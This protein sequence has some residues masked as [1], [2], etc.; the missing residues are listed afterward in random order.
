M[1]I[2]LIGAHPDDV[3]IGAGGF[4]AKM[5]TPENELMVVACS[6]CEEQEGNHGITEEFRNSMK[7]LGIENFRMLDFPNTRMPEK[8]SDIRI[9]MEKLKQSF[10]PDLVVTH[11]INNTHQDHKTIAEVC[12]RVFREKSIFMFEELRSTPKFVHNLIV[13]LEKEHLEK[14][15]MALECYKTQ[16]RRYYF[17]MDYVRSLAGV[18]GKVV[19]REFAEAFE[20]YQHVW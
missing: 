16:F 18:R 6:N 19:N 8:A 5:N 4:I 7:T 12:I 15:I 17:S 14:K 11:N 20:I 3:E 1:K 10:N 13:P 2:L 9:E